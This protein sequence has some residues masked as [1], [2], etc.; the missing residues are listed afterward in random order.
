MKNL[1]RKMNCICK[2]SMYLI[3]QKDFFSEFRVS[4]DNIVWT[5]KY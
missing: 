1:I 5:K 3:N 2:L 4:G